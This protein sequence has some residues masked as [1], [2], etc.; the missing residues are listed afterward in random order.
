MLRRILLIATACSFTSSLPAVAQVDPTET[1]QPTRP[2]PPLP[3]E[4]PRPTPPVRVEPSP[5]LPT[6]SFEGLEE[7]VTVKKIEILGSTVFSQ[8]ELEE[9]TEPFINRTLTFEQILDVRIAVTKLYISR[10]Y[11][12]S[13]AFLPIQDFTSGNLQVQVVE[14]EIERVEIQGLR[15]LKQG[16]V[17]SRLEAA[18][19]APVSIPKLES[20]L[21]LL[22]LNPL[23]ESL[24]VQLSNGSAPGRNILTVNLTE[25]PPFSSTLLLD[26]KEPPSVG[27]FGGTVILIH[28][29]LLGFGDR[30]DVARGIT[31]GVNNYSM[32]Y[33]IPINARNG[34]L[35]LRYTRG[36]NEVIEEPFDPLEITGLTQTYT[37]DFRQPVIL[38][39][40]EELALGVSAQLGRSRTFLFDDEPF[41]FTEGP[42]NGESKVSVL[43]FSTD[44]LNRRSPNAVLAA[45]SI[46]SL[47]LGIFDATTNQ[48]GTD[49]R[50]VSWQG[51]FQWV[52]AL[53]TRRDTV[54][55]SRVV[56][57]L[58]PNSLL[59]LEQFAIGGTDSVRGYRTNQA[60]ASNGLFG[61]VEVRFPIVRAEES[62]FGLLQLTPFIDV[63]SVWGDNSSSQTLLSTGLGLRWQLGD[64][65]LARLDWG[66]PLVSVDDQGD[67]LQ[68]DGISFSLQ[69]NFF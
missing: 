27:S 51:Q 3:Q 32:S 16:Y 47:G 61:S 12:T 36:R 37:I 59:P 40:R 44:W 57:Q 67:S 26:N 56:A 5:S 4:L 60:V 38:T 50:F 33:Q 25:A 43:R 30:L 2:N 8:Q 13:G 65:I 53:N 63:G 18:M 34:T 42:E 15:R 20:A 22:Q 54:L 68:D 39:P 69:T 21:Q 45:S 1:I 24:N 66:I 41:S 10:G 35:G 58:T 11:A 46:F 49:G 64:S 7:K 31:Q 55:I 14:G 9:V 62:G 48:T 19:K 29:N 52:Q 6:E 17:R 28:N 23:F